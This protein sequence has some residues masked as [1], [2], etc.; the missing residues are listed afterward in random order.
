MPVVTE[1]WDLLS[2]VLLTKCLGTFNSSD[3]GKLCFPLS[4]HFRG[5]PESLYHYHT[6][7]TAIPTCK[8][9]KEW[10]HQI[11]IFRKLYSQDEILF[12]IRLSQIHTSLMNV[13][14]QCLYF[15]LS[16]NADS[17]MKQIIKKSHKFKFGHNLKD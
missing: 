1:I 14:R 12:Q 7:G 2:S 9:W 8:A 15:W 5:P 13:S 16:I 10:L 4:L 11:I 6:V 3:F 17:K